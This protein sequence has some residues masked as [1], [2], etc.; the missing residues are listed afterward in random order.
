MSGCRVMGSSV[1]VPISIGLFVPSLVSD[2]CNMDKLL[3]KTAV[4]SGYA[5]FEGEGLFQAFKH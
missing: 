2:T 3:R 4:L 1:M 5:S